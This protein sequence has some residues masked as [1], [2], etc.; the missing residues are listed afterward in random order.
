METK[1]ALQRLGWRFSEAIKKSDN[2]FH[3]NSNDLEAL[4]A[5]NR[6]IQEHQKQ[7]YEHNE[8]FAKLYIYLFQK[9]LENDNATVMDKEP[10]RK[11]YNLLKKP[12]H[13]IISDLTQSLNDSE[14]YEVLEKAGALMDHPAIE[15]NEKRINSTKA[16][17]RAL[18]D[19]ENTQKFLGDVWDY[20]T[21]SEIVQTEIN[22]A[23]NIFK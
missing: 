13:S 22:Q 2:S 9:I 15:S 1:K 20:E 8:L 6:A 4:K 17:Q 11:I 23:I 7:Q 10:R 5:I 14:R 16:M 21:V 18:K 3:I 19:N 12:L